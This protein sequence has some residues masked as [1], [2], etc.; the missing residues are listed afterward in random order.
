MARLPRELKW[1]GGMSKKSKKVKSSTGRAIFFISAI[2]RKKKVRLNGIFQFRIASQN[3]LLCTR[4]VADRFEYS[5]PELEKALRRSCRL[6]TGNDNEVV[7][8][9][10]VGGCGR[11][12]RAEGLGLRVLS[13]C[14]VRKLNFENV[15]RP[16]H[17]LHALRSGDR[18]KA[19]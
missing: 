19:Y 12:A 13:G 1:D 6:T 18:G 9:L 15:F 16:P 4:D 10:D 7:L 17:L 8:R 3:D 14:S 2:F 5:K 11:Y